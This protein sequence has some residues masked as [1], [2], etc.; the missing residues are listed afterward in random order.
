MSRRKTKS[1]ERVQPQKHASP[2]CVWLVLVV[3][4]AGIAAYANSFSG[5]FLLDDYSH[6]LLNDAIRDIGQ[7]GAVLSE[8]RRPLVNLTLA[9]NYALSEFDTPSY[10]VVN[11][12]IHLLAGMTLFGIVRRTL[13]LEPFRQR[14]AGAAP[15]LAAATALLWTVH[16]LQTQSV[17]YI[18]QRGESLMGL[19]YLLTLYCVLHGAASPRGGVAWHVA[20]VI[21]CALGMASKAV[22][23]SAP[24]V[25]L[26]Y[27]WIFLSRSLRET[28]RK[29][30][31]LY[32]G[33]C[34]TWGVLLAVGVVQ[35]VLFPRADVSSTVGFGSKDL[36]PLGYLLTQPG[37]ILHYLRLSL[38]PHPLCLDYQWPAAKTVTTVVPA[39]SVVTALLVGTA[40]A[41][42]RCRWAGFL[43]AWFFIILAPTSSFI[44]IKDL[45]FE[46]RMYLPL[47]AVMVLVVIGVHFLLRRV[48]DRGAL[49]ATSVRWIQC[50]LVAIVAV[51]FCGL[52]IARNRDYLSESTMW[53]DVVD[54]RPHNA[55]AWSSLGVALGKEG[56]VQES[57]EAYQQAIEADPEMSAA[58]V[59]MGKALVKLGRHAEAIHAFQTG[60]ALDPQNA[61]AYNS[62]ANAYRRTK[63]PEKALDA[64][65]EAVRLDPENAD[66]R[67]NLASV[68]IQTRQLDEA[69]KQLREAIL[70]QPNDFEARLRLARVLNQQRRLDEAV[71]EYRAASRLRP[72]RTDVHYELGNVLLAQKQLPSALEA[73]SAAIQRNP[74]LT[75][76]RCNRG[77][78]LL[79]LARPDEAI[80]EFRTVLQEDARHVLAHYHLGRAHLTQGRRQEAAAAFR[81]ALEIAPNHAPSRSALAAI[82]QRQ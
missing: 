51:L 32:L 47:A 3:S 68:L 5:V 30:W 65:R 74:R 44:P 22:M 77:I 7:L 42:V 48:S 16:P 6:I 66:H 14:Y 61:K 8:G 11:I 29:R 15:W 78:A 41:V 10:H 63:Q 69:A 43:G 36:T 13:L 39:G 81:E 76:A 57:M 52:T 50:G 27:D 34:A 4:V 18:I 9:I 70:C 37:V 46:H 40:W 19:F 24:V 23:V 20:A 71:V 45:A 55:R 60:L 59:N 17:T 35:G 38:V 21:A 31:G 79:G 56:C 80:A 82:S 12:A 28:L 58:H 1:Y 72:A 25:V 73:Y 2:A 49:A 53:R 64:Y 54:Q 26:L 67:F 33:L 62:L 75:D